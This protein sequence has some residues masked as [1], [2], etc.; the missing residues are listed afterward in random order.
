MRV[1]IEYN[2]KFIDVSKPDCNYGSNLAIFEPMLAKAL[3]QVGLIYNEN[4][5]LEEE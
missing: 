1:L 5:D 3:E 4:G 2:N